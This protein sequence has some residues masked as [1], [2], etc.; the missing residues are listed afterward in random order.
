MIPCEVQHATGSISVAWCQ[1]SVGACTSRQA[2][3]FFYPMCSEGMHAATLSNTLYTAYLRGWSEDNLQHC[4]L[5]TQHDWS[6][7]PASRHHVHPEALCSVAAPAVDDPPWL[8]PH[9]ATSRHCQSDAAGVSA[10]NT[11]KKMSQHTKLQVS[12]AP[13][14]WTWGCKVLCRVDD[15]SWRDRQATSG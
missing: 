2:E 10:T 6:A 14:C 7:V 15:R 12:E 3:S 4:L 11:H 9:H 5:K 8:E 1:Q 13:H